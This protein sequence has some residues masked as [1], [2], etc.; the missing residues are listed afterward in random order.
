[1]NIDFHSFQKYVEENLFDCIQRVINIKAKKSRKESYRLSIL[2]S[3]V[4]LATLKE[5]C[6]DDVNI[7]NKYLGHE[8]RLSMTNFIFRK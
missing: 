5:I 4:P 8:P 3:R 1:M 6:E 2:N 7:L